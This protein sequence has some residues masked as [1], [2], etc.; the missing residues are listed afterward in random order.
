MEAGGA[1]HRQ[2]RGD[3]GEAEP[4][5]RGDESDRGGRLDAPDGVWRL[6]RAGG[7]AR[8]PDQ[9]V[10]ERPGSGSALVSRV[11]RQSISAAA[12]RGGVHADP[13]AAGWAGGNG[14]GGS[15]SGNG[16]A[17]VAES[18]GAGDRAKSQGAGALADELSAAAGVA[19]AGGVA[20]ERVGPAARTRAAVGLS[21]RRTPPRKRTDKET[22]RG[23]TRGHAWEG[24]EARATP[25]R[26]GGNGPAKEWKRSRGGFRLVPERV[27]SSKQSSKLQTLADL[28][29]FMHNPG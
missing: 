4:P 18:S 5:V 7:R 6:L 8:E 1:H 15:A 23:R 11:S 27:P 21:R 19:A 28:S 26:E 14:A 9:G 10:Q 24:A 12:A 20:A 3:P 22:E 25:L 13:D 29:A 16:A 17:G 2:S